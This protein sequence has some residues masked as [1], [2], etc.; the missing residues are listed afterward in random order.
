MAVVHGGVQANIKE[1]NPKALFMP[2]ANHSLNIRGVHSLCDFSLLCYLSFST[3]VLEEVN[4]TQKYLQTSGPG[5]AGKVCHK[6][7]SPSQRTQIVKRAIFYANETRLEYF[8]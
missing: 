2:C 8:V 5:I 3:E 6:H 1:H 4:Q 7:Q